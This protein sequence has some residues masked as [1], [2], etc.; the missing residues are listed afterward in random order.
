MNDTWRSFM[1]NLIDGII[2]C[3][4]EQHETDKVY[5]QFCDTLTSEMDK[6]LKYTSSSRPLRKRL[7][8]SKPYWNQELYDLWLKMSTSE[9][10]FSRYNGHRNIR[11]QLREKYKSE[12]AIFDKELRKA[13]RRYNHS[14]LE[15][16]E[17][18]STNITLG[19]F[20]LK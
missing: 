15:K 16:L 3:R 18:I 20:G 17:N 7:K 13:E 10:E 6:Y 8:N 11:E 4:N 5:T 19:N 9:N 2:L 1:V 14:V 12:R